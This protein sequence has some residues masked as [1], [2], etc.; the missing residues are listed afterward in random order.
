MNPWQKFIS[1]NLAIHESGNLE[2]RYML[3]Y[4]MKIFSICSSD[5]VDIL[6][7]FQIHE[8]LC[9][10]VQ[11]WHWHTVSRE[12]RGIELRRAMRILPPVHNLHSYND[13]G[14]IQPQTYIRSHIRSP[15]TE[16]LLAS[17]L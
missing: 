13:V 17:T 1:A 2:C 14:F 15:C 10:S 7:G 12:W 3:N 4:C 8:N 16:I 11:W 6:T 5:L 9:C